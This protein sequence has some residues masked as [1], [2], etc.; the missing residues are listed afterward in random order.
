[1]FFTYIPVFRRARAYKGT[2]FYRIGT[3][4]R[5]CFLLCRNL[6]ITHVGIDV[7]M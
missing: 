5:P 7:P 2:F 4:I 6:H 3:N 1:M